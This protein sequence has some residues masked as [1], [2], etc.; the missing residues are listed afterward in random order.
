MTKPVDSRRRVL[1]VAYNFPP[2]AAIGTMR[3]L[4]VVRQLHA[5]GWDVSVL[6]GDP[7]TS[8]SGNAVDLALLEQVPR[9]V[10]VIR[11]GA[12]H[13]WSQLQNL[14]LSRY[15]RSRS[16]HQ[17]EIG[18][19]T[20]GPAARAASRS[21]GGTL[22]RVVRMKDLVDAALSI[23]DRYSGW[24]L[25]ALSKGVISGLRSTP[26]DVIY[27]S[28]PPWTTQLV[29]AGLKQA[30][31]RPWVADFRDPWSRAPWRGD[32][33]RFAMT[34]AARLERL[35]VR[36]A[37]RV[38]FVTAANR[39]DFAAYYGQAIAAKFDVV[40]NGCDPDEFDALRDTPRSDTDTFVMLHAGSLYAGRTPVPLLKAIATAVSRGDV[41]RDRFR[42]RFLGANALTGVDLAGIC[43]QLGL[44]DVVQFLPRVPR[45]QSLRAMM[46][47]SSLLL[48]QPG[49]TL[50]VPGKVY[51][52]LA[53]GRPIFAIAE[54]GEISELVRK[55][56]VGVLV[57]PKDEGAIV[58]AFAAHV[59]RGSANVA[60]PPRELYDGN[61]R[62]A[63]TA[64]I[65]EAMVDGHDVRAIA[66]VGE[67]F[68]KRT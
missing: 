9:E 48:L 10:R 20:N 58:E 54:E 39:D 25:P 59:R 2:H 7:S 31:R 18:G 56:G 17:S 11:A 60:P 23:P 55:T 41:D 13:P 3:T 64:R 44:E 21:T 28:A 62:A 30:L 47:A 19:F 53:T 14:V 52:Y 37:D 33:Y 1:I 12:L 65:L 42:L 66:H 57:S 49:H 29:A 68:T 67:G 5:R 61:V 43:R 40:P 46:A 34:A 4:R 50:S 35:V 15:R 63:R 16:P 24:L 45:E 51:E 32:R 8:P 36:H 6:T 22:A 26:P 38:I 27:S